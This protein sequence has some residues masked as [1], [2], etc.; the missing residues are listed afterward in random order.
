VDSH[1][2]LLLLLLSLSSVEHAS[3]SIACGK[4][5]GAAR[6]GERAQLLLLVVV[7]VVVV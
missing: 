2:L 1:A 7:V 4:P 5:L 6:L 3:P